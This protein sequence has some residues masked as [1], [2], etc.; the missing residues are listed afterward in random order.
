MVSKIIRITLNMAVIVLN[1]FRNGGYKGIMYSAILFSEIYSPQNI[2]IMP[3][4]KA[5]RLLVSEI[6]VPLWKCPPFFK[7]ASKMM[8]TMA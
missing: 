1:G 8:Y 6:D 4:L 7:M 2:Y 3:I 5:L